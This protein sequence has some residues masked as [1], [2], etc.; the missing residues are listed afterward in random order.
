[1]VFRDHSR[2][3]APEGVRRFLAGPVIEVNA[4]LA[5]LIEQKI[6]RALVTTD[7]FPDKM[8][9]RGWRMP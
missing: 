6:A 4:K 3:T 9:P 2:N 7:S 1:M 8:L 5:T